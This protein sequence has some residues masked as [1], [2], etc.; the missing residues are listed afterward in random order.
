MRT[1]QSLLSMRDPD[2][3]KMSSMDDNAS[4]TLS[5]DH[6]HHH[7][8]SSL[9]L[10]PNNFANSTTLPPDTSSTSF[11]SGG[12]DRGNES[13]NETDNSTSNRTTLCK[14]STSSIDANDNLSL[15]PRARRSLDA[16][17]LNSGSSK[18]TDDEV[19]TN[20]DNNFVVDSIAKRDFFNVESR[21]MKKIEKD[22]VKIRPKPSNSVS[23]A[24]DES[25]FSSMS[26]FQVDSLF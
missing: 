3:M 18:T 13:S 5:V 10:Q 8:E 4:M 17:S 11:I 16:T 23:S 22:G 20:A 2:L 19:L 21:A 9:S 12:S 26:S 25:G 1:V 7:H 14:N 24:E 15:L 6:H